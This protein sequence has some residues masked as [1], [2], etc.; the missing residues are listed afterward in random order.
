MTDYNADEIR[1]AGTGED[2]VVFRATPEISENRAVNF[3]E[4]SDIRHPGGLLIY[5]GTQ[6]RSFDI[7]AKFISRTVEEA[8][9]SYKF[10]HLLKSWTM[11]I[12]KDGEG[13]DSG[14]GGYKNTPEV[15][16]LFGYDKGDKGQFKGIPVVITSLNISFPPDVNYIEDENGVFIPII[17]SV[18][19]ALK[20]ARKY[21]ELRG[22]DDGGVG[23]K[24][25]DYKN[26]ELDTW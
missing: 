4:I 15:I 23:F 1:L 19:I 5:I 14:T 12:K 2:L 9:E 21:S 8:T 24:M 6:P 22:R 13:W 20:E 17:Q 26:G 3:S 7:S 18:S 11:P 16:N 10:T 25:Q